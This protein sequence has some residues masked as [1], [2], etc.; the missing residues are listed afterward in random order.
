FD[1]YGRFDG[2]A[3]LIKTD[4]SDESW[5][6]LGLGELFTHSGPLFLQL[7]WVSRHLGRLHSV[8]DHLDAFISAGLPRVEFRTTGKLGVPLEEILVLRVF[9]ALKIRHDRK[10]A[11]SRL[12]RDLY[13]VL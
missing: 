4:F 10:G 1:D 3:V 13:I 2:N 8:Q 9:Y 12:A 6:V 11:I 7:G 5:K